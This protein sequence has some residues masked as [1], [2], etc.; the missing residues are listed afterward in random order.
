MARLHKGD[1][2]RISLGV[3]VVWIG[4]LGLMRGVPLITGD[5]VSI[6]IALLSGVFGLV[7]VAIGGV[8]VLGWVWAK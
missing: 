5:A 4:V 7:F 8:M 2:V 6:V 1:A 3:V